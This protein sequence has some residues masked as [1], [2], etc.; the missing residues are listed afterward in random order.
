MGLFFVPLFNLYWPFPSL[1]GLGKDVRVYVECSGSRPRGAL[2][3]LGLSLAILTCVNLILWSGYPFVFMAFDDYWDAYEA[4][5]VYGIVH[6]VIYLA[7]IVIWIL[8]YIG[9]ARQLNAIKRLRR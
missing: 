9:I 1:S 4:Y 5:I 6:G 7:E 8:F 3:S 2:A